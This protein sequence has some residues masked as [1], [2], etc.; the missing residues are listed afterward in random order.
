MV[1]IGSGNILLPA[2]CQTI[3]SNNADLLS[4]ETLRIIFNE[5]DLIISVLDYGL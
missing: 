3:T 2:K 5:A 4:V 1:N